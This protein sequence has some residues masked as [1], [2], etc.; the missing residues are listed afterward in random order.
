MPKR[1]R[2][3]LGSVSQ[4]LSIGMLPWR[5][6]DLPQVFSNGTT[7]R[8][9]RSTQRALKGSQDQNTSKALSLNNYNLRYWDI[10]NSHQFVDGRIQP[11]IG[12]PRLREVK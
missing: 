1:V 8:I 9:K 7:L 11:I 6:G 12:T 5:P 3:W 4:L 10:R 2:S